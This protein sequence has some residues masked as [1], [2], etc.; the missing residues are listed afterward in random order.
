MP[1]PKRQR[2]GRKGA[3]AAARKR[4]KKQRAG[5]KGGKAR[6]RKRKIRR[7]KKRS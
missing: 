4:M 3:R 2:A 1:N 6:A 5:R 7:L